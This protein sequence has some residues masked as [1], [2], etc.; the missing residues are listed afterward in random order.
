M[1]L[2][3]ARDA[4]IDGSFPDFLRAF[5]KTYYE[6][7]LSDQAKKVEE[8]VSLCYPKWCVDALRSVGVD[9]LEGVPEAR[10]VDGSGAK[11]DYA[12]IKES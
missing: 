12:G 10:I 4:I 2:G 6:G 3:K 1:L 5:F 7:H 11:W 8:G 9:I